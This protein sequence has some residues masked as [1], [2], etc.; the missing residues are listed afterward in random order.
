MPNLR[1]QRAPATVKKNIIDLN[2][3]PLVTRILYLFE[4]AIAHLLLP[5]VPLLML[6]RSRKEPVHFRK[7]LDRFALGA[8]GHRCAVWI[9]AASLGETR[10]ASPL[11]RQLRAEGFNVLLTH[12]SPSGLAEGARLFANDSGVSQAFVPLDLF[13]AVR[14]FLRRFQPIALIVM[15]IE[16]WPAMLIET[17]RKGIPIAMANGNLLEQSIG[18]GRGLRS[19]LLKLYLLFSHICTRTQNYYDRYIRLGVDPSRVSV[20]GEMKYDQL[21]DPAHLRM[22]KTLRTNLVGGERFL[23]IAS[24]VEAEESLLLPMVERL[25]AQDSGLRVLWAP[26][27]PQRFQRV[28]DELRSKGIAVTLRS[29][30]GRAM[31]APMPQTRVLVVDSTGEMNAFYPAA[32]LVFVG[33]SL[34]DHGGHNIIE[35]LV[36]G[37]PV[38]MGPSTY[39]VDFAAEPAGQAGA[40]ESLL[41]ASALEERI[42]ELMAD[43]VSLAQMSA[44]SVAFAADKTGAAK[45]T[46]LVIHSLFGTIGEGQSK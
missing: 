35:P 7:L 23:M 33:A 19:H 4:Q 27:S 41:D 2:A 34:V 18:N 28:A 40:F 12:Q 44:A 5:F 3:L 6:I 15:E 13:W 29:S 20:V 14:I 31:D 43:P 36:L 32:D 38:V 45:K 24:S 17:T 39:G 21:I 16:I 25:I 37:R 30:L 10:A 1:H 22:A 42:V 26:R 8:V 11:I 9:Y 46:L